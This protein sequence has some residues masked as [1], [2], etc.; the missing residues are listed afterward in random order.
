M[1]PVMVEPLMVMPPM[2]LFWIFAYPAKPANCIY[3]GDD[4]RDVKAS[5]AAGIKPIVARYGYLGNDG[6][7]ES[8]GADHLIDHPKELTHY[9]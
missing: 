5:L 2:V 6:P 9:L 8:W 1:A 3:L 4:I 7:P